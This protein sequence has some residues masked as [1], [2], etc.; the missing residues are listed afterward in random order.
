MKT[1]RT[2]PHQR[3][4][5]V[6]YGNAKC[7]VCH[8]VYARSGPAQK[9]CSPQCAKQHTKLTRNYKKQSFPG[10]V[11]TPWHNGLFDGQ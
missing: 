3:K 10:R 9:S 11:D 4:G 8:R 7:I 5:S 2:E 1:T 6:T